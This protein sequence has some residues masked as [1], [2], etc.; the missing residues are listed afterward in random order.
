MQ[1]ILRFFK[2]AFKVEGKKTF[3]EFYIKLNKAVMPCYRNLTP[4]FSCAP[5][6]I[7]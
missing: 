1:V 2:K 3:Y 4:A 6:G 7:H 5:V